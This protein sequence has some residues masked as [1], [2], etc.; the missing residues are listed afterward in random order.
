LVRADA[1]QLTLKIE[2]SVEVAGKRFQS[3]PQY[4]DYGYDG[5]LPGQ[6]SEAKNVGSEGLTIDGEQVSC[7]IR[8][9][10]ATVGQQQQITKLYLSDD[11]EPFVLKRDTTVVKNGTAVPGEPQTTAEVIAVDVP[12]KVLHDVKSAA[13]ERTT[14]KSSRGTNISLDILCVDVPGGV[15]ARTSKEFDSQGHLVRRSTLSLV[16][17]RAVDDDDDD[18]AQILTRRQARKARRR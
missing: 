3:P 1:R 5:E 15:V 13:Y 11:V 9:V 10:V 12:Y 14:Q 8:Q 4:I 16:D 6:H 18:T 17:Y 7:Q 2:A